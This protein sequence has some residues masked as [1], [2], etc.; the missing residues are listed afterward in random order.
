MYYRCLFLMHFGACPV[1]CVDAAFD[2]VD[3]VIV[4]TFEMR[5]SYR[6]IDSIEK[7]KYM[8]ARKYTE[9]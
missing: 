9:E 1:L 5:L 3:V 6:L 4:M 7:Q 8:G 2:G